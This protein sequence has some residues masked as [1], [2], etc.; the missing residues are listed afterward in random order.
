M[1]ISKIVSTNLMCVSTT[2]KRFTSQLHI[3]WDGGTDGTTSNCEIILSDR[4]FYKIINMLPTRY[5]AARH[6]EGLICR[7]DRIISSLFFLTCGGLYQIGFYNYSSWLTHVSIHSIVTRNGTPIVCH[8]NVRFFVLLRCH[9]WS[10]AHYGP[11]LLFRSFDFTCE[12][13]NTRPMKV[14]VLASS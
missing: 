4:T 6:Q 11:L 1:T 3:N 13:V 8:S 10:L 14:R 5:L 2:I 12:H 9:A 7:C